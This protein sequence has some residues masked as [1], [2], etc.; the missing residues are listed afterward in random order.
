ME[1]FTRYSTDVQHFWLLLVWCDAAFDRAFEYLC[2]VV[3][4]M[5]GN[6]S[7]WRWRVYFTMI[8]KIVIKSINHWLL[9]WKYLN[10]TKK[11]EHFKCSISIEQ[12]SGSWIVV[13][14]HEPCVFS[15]YQ[16][17]PGR[18]TTLIILLELK[19]SVMPPCWLGTAETLAFE[20]LN[21]IHYFMTYQVFGTLT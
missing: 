6:S 7:T 14:L 13:N 11:I 17:T 2:T 8:Q 3:T 16:G 21:C 19:L 4:I 10:N 18:S 9:D 20:P 15:V 1:E 12:T 5:C